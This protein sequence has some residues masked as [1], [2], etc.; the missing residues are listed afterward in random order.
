MPPIF[1]GK[2]PVTNNLYKGLRSIDKLPKKKIADLDLSAFI[3][4]CLQYQTFNLYFITPI[5]KQ[6]IKY[7]GH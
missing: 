4:Q 2:Y 1:T 5:I 3:K 6:T 7:S